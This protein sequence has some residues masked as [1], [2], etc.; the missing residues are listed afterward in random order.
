MK[1]RN[2]RIAEENLALVYSVA[3]RI[4]RAIGHTIELDELVSYGTLGLMQALQRFD[5]SRG[6]KWS[7]Y[8]QHRIRGAI[9]DGVRQLCPVPA[10]QYRGQ[11]ERGETAKVRSGLQPDRVSAG[12]VPA[13][14]ALEAWELRGLLRKALR[15][16]PADERELLHRHY[17][18]EQNLL[19]AGARRGFTKSWASRRHSRAIDRLRGALAPALAPV[20]AAA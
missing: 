2:T 18:K 6:A 19:E 15:R 14:E 5:P 11:L 1:P 3:D 13:D 4:G 10:K 9:W 7:T 16:L 20:M 8:A 12:A 17:W